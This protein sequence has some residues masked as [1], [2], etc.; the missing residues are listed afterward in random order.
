MN[1]ESTPNYQLPLEL[2]KTFPDYF[3]RIDGLDDQSYW[4]ALGRSSFALDA[5]LAVVANDESHA[6][7]IA[8]F[9]LDLYC[10]IAVDFDEEKFMKMDFSIYLNVLTLMYLK[11]LL[12]RPISRILPIDPDKQWM[13]Y[14]MRMEKVLGK[15]TK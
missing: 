4:H 12:Q 13:L 8:D 3:K 7:S 11:S 10:G 6:D 2:K 15:T 9:L 5:L 1:D 14:T